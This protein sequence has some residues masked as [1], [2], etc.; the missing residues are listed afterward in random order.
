MI[1]E[2][3]DI[4]SFGLINDMTL[5]FS[6]GV[7]V[8]EGQNESGKT[9]IAAFIKYMLFGFDTREVEGVISE[10]EKRISW[11]R[12][13]AEGAMTVRV[14]GKRY[15]ITRKTTPTEAEGS[16]RAYKEESG[17]ID[18]ESGASAFGR[19]PAGEVF[20]GVTRELF[21]NTA[22]VGQI[23]DSAI[24]SGSVKESIEN[25][26]FS[27]S[28]RLNNQ[29]AMSKISDR[30]EALIHRNE[31]GGT[32]YDLANKR[33]QLEE[34]MRRADDDN[35]Q[36]LVKESELHAIRRE[37]KDAE[38][39]LARLYD[40]DSCYKNVMLIQ[41]F[42]KLHELEEECA[43]K[44]EAYDNFIA[45]NTRAGY[46]PDEK[47]M[48]D[49]ALARR[50]VN[51]TYAALIEAEDN[52][53]K[54][55]N[56]IGITNEIENAIGLSDEHGGEA[57][58]I[59]SAKGYRRGIIR[60]ILLL[61]L[62]GV[63]ALAAAVCEIAAT[64]FFATTLMRVLIGVAC[65]AA[66]GGAG[67]FAYSIVKNNK[68]LSALAAK[69]GVLSFED[70]VGKIGVIG[71]ARAKRDG[72]IRSTDM[73]REAAENARAAYEV[74]RAEL[75]EVILRWGEEPPTSELNEFIDGLEERVNAFLA[76]RRELSDDKNMIE[77]TVREIRRT[78][79]ETNE[80]DIRAQVPPLKR[81]SLAGINHDEIITGISAEKARIAD[82]EKRAYV[83]ENEL[84]ALKAR[85][86]DPGDYYS[87]IYGVESRIKEL[88]ARH[89]AYSVAL[90]AIEN[91][92]D[93]LRE[94]ISPRLGGYAT[95]LMEVMTDKKYSSFGVD[96]SLSVS[97]TAVD[98]EDKSVDFLSGGTRDLAYIAVRMA[99]IDMLYGEKPPVC[100]D[101]SF[102]HQ[103]NNRA[104][105][106]MRAIAKIAAEG[107]QSFV[108]TCRA[109]EGALAG[110]LASPVRVYKLSVLDNDNI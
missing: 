59:S 43:A 84:N 108:F 12:G 35:K 57:E 30:M 39:K 21:E 53:A 88:R 20:L 24:D 49:L 23:G 101:E 80:I 89:R 61:S 56:A 46:V 110:E 106:M 27:G 104:R 45:E 109:R 6:E 81:K 48:T 97:F 3:I 79:S 71:E 1:I 36:I 25:I 73:A 7:N 86:S 85:A 107:S 16:R 2:R 47:Y 54:E 70:L 67:F 29:R 66:L 72:M 37:K 93:N 96:D 78:L 83:V 26:L 64:G 34:T 77:L 40:S 102:A 18:M 42:D 90:S 95:S 87:R 94:E 28:E 14:K 5:E 33:D 44:T 55:K 60:G 22:F 75:T 68:L 105:S 13:A 98:G 100:F 50:A 76:R 19:V 41:T 38:D 51:D 17:I 15:Y 4:K 103:D 99:L 32:V 62:L 10:R 82:A 9:T 65:A 69:F 74:A 92:S 8:I 58:V 63:T 91:A 31:R 11:T 52:Y